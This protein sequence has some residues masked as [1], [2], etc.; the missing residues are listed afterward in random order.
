M[1]DF[2]SSYKKITGFEPYPYQIKAF[3]FLSQGRSVILCAPTGSGKS[4]AVFMPFLMCR[5]TTLPTRLIYVLPMRVLVNSLCDR[6]RKHGGKHDPS[7]RIERQ[8]GK[9]PESLLFYA[10]AVVATLDQVISSYACSPLSL[11]LRHGN[12]PA[13]AIASGFLVFD[14]VHTFEPE[15]GLQSSLLL[16]DRLRLLKLPFVFMSATLPCSLLNFMKERFDLSDEEVIE[17]DEREIPS[18]RSRRV[19]LEC[20]LSQELTPEIINKLHRHHKGRTIVV[21]NTVQRA[22]DLYQNL[23]K[24]GLSKLLLTHSRFLDQD[25]EE[26]EREISHLFDPDASKTNALLITTQVV[27]VGMDISCDLLLT[28]IAPVDALIQRAGRCCRRGG[29]GRIVIFKADPAPYNEEIVEKTAAAIQ[30][31]DGAILT[32]KLEKALVDEV[33]GK[34]YSQYA[35]P[36]AGAKAVRLLSQAAFS[37]SRVKASRAIREPDLTVEISIH[38]DPGSLNKEA[39]FLPRIGIPLSIV[40]RFVQ[41]HRP[42]M[43]EIE[44]DRHHQ[45]DYHPVVTTLQVNSARNIAPGSFYVISSRFASYSLERGF[46]LGDSGVPFMPQ[47]PKER[48]PLASELRIETIR[49]HLNRTIK[50]FENLILPKEGH[51]IK[52]LASFFGMKEDALLQLVRACLILHDLG[53]LTEEW[54]N[55]AWEITNRWVKEPGNLEKLSKQEQTILDK[56]EGF[57]AHFPEIKGDERLPPHASISAYA[58]RPFFQKYWG[59]VV[60]MATWTAIAHHHSV[61]AREVRPYCLTSGWYETIREIL[62]HQTGM[63]LLKEDIRDGTNLIRST[64]LE[65]VIPPF[66][67]PK[68]Y[69]IYLMLSRWLR[70]ADWMAVGGEN[71]ILDYEKWAGNL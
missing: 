70:L 53:K 19:V 5:G 51:L 8:H 24:T 58:A 20:R 9:H 23:E 68:T 22:T 34:F 48:E 3:Q 1:K 15:L 27:E 63:E 25:R 11:S 43:W 55:K 7:L 28:E 66:D 40:R 31:Y 60:D 47:L 42:D 16:A 69:T 37:G 18:R 33:L 30:N 39:L 46:I 44:V 62:K 35:K 14:E 57:L 65:I 26:K 59:K 4:E 2:V 54:Q 61:R 41:E 38:D 13:G 71:A 12:I 17:V 29:S 50:A 10:E 6:F 21:V 56:N 52:S 67:H 49:E 36:K 32:W 64:K 45:D